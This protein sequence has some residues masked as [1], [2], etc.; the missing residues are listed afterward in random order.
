M[1]E[2]NACSREVNL[3][4]F[5]CLVIQVIDGIVRAHREENTKLRAEIRNHIRSNLCQNEQMIQIGRRLNE[6][7][8]NLQRA[9][10]EVVRLKIKLDELAVNENAPNT[11]PLRVSHSSNRVVENLKFVLE[12]EEETPKVEQPLK[13]RVVRQSNVDPI[14]P[15]PIKNTVAEIINSDSTS[16]VEQV[17]RVRFVETR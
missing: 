1:D 6:S 10:A 5:P 14:D 16:A 8:K 15:L 2:S 17:S 11:S 13:E 3:D 7:E 9:R 4:F 12:K